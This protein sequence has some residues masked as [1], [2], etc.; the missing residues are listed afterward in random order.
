MEKKMNQRDLRPDEKVLYN[1]ASNDQVGK[2]PS[3][4]TSPISPVWRQKFAFKGFN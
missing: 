1:E 2:K 4:I 3:I